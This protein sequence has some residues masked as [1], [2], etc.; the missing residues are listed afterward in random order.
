MGMTREELRRYYQQ[1]I[2][3]ARAAMKKWQAK[4]DNAPPATTKH[5]IGVWH[6]R[7]RD[8]RCQIKAAQRRIRLQ[9]KKL[10]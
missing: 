5:Q 6:G 7:V 10:R 3:N 8:Y 1:Q 2:V 4:I 9:R